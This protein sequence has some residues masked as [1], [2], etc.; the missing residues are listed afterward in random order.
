MSI[1][2]YCYVM[3]NAGVRSVFNNDRVGVLG[4]FG[5]GR[6]LGGQVGIDQGAWVGRLHAKMRGGVRGREARTEAGGAHGLVPL[7]ENFDDEL[8][9]YVLGQFA[10]KRF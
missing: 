6:S 4:S 8:H 5:R 9:L 7:F 2:L 1:I 10:H 3:V